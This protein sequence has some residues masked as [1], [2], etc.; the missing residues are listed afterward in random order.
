MAFWNLTPANIQQYNTKTCGCWWYRN[1][2]AWIRMWSV[3]WPD[4]SGRRPDSVRAASGGL[5]V[6]FSST[7]KESFQNIGAVLLSHQFGTFIGQRRRPRSIRSSDQSFIKQQLI[8]NLS[9]FNVSCQA[10]RGGRILHCFSN[11]NVCIITAI[12]ACRWLK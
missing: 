10:A 1:G 9:S 2:L 3:D 7:W 8:T 12:S 6:A 5:R 11:T 4:G